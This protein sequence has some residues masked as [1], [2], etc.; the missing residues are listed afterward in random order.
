MG[1]W[2]SFQTSRIKISL[3]DPWWL[4]MS[5]LWCVG[6]TAREDC[7]LLL[8][9]DNST[10]REDYSSLLSRDNCTAS[11]DYLSLL[12]HYN[13]TAREDYLSLLSYYNCTAREDYLSLLSPNNCAVP[14]YDKSGFFRVTQQINRLHRLSHHQISFFSKTFILDLLK[15]VCLQMPLL[16]FKTCLWE[17][18]IQ[19]I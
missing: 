19:M 13:C 2:L 1:R 14:F 8:P 17:I 7:S 5:L 18:L 11:G 9:R 4:A 10:A 3:L 12:S 16:L 15:V 6:F